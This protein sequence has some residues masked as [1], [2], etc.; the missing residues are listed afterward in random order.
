M[1]IYENEWITFKSNGPTNRRVPHKLNGILPIWMVIYQ[2]EWIMFKLNIIELRVTNWKSMDHSR[3]HCQI[4]WLTVEWPTANWI[5]DFT[6]RAWDSPRSDP[7]CEDETGSS[8]WTNC[9]YN[10]ELHCWKC[11]HNLDLICRMNCLGLPYCSCN[12]SAVTFAGTNSNELI[13]SIN[14]VPPRLATC[15]YRL[16]SSGYNA[17]VNYAGHPVRPRFDMSREQ[18]EYFLCYDLG[19]QDITN[20]PSVS[21]STVQQRFLEY[22]ISVNL[23]MSRQTND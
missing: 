7:V 3:H 1:A 10:S 6:Q 23:A 2:N 18:L 17:L 9:S 13:T 12:S 5:L 15:A 22:G 14:L 4:E 19:A 11:W 8:W 20:A 16:C 21:K